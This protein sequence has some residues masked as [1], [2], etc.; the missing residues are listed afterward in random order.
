MYTNNNIKTAVVLAGGRGTRL[1]SVV[2]DLPKPMAIVSNRHFLE[3]LLDYWIEQGITEFIICVCYLSEKIIN[4]FGSTY[5]GVSIKYSVERI[6]LGTGGAVIAAH[7]YIKNDFL[8]LNGDTF[9]PINLKELSEFHLKNRADF[10][11]AL[12]KSSDS[13]RYLPVELLKSK[14][15]SFN[16]KSSV[17]SFYVNGGIYLFSRDLFKSID[18]ELDKY[19]S[20][21]NDIFPLLL[22]KVGVFGL[23][24]KAPFIDIGVPSDY[25]RAHEI[26][27]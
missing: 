22:K 10:S 15:I 24:I 7:R 26:L 4:H 5:R 8:V 27:L 25:S 21:E 13:S 2:L 16:N 18:F 3:Y 19:Y 23:P 6:P 11:L 9:F 12:F 17:D 14:V 20:L 1:R